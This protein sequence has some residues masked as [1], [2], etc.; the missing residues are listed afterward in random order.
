[1]L[2]YIIIGA[3]IGAF[4][5]RLIPPGYFFW[6]VIGGIIGYAVKYYMQRR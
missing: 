1:M 4:A 6:F 5:G 3:V 2:T